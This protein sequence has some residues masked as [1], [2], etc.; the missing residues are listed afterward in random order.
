MNLPASN[1]S[2]IRGQVNPPVLLT[3]YPIIDQS[4]VLQANYETLRRQGQSHNMAEMLTF[5]QSPGAQTDR[6]F[7]MGHQRLA[8]QVGDDPMYMQQITSNYRAATGGL[9]PNINDQYMPSLANFPG[10]P[11]AFVSSAGD[12]KRLAEERNVSVSGFVT[13]KASEPIADPFGVGV[14]KGMKRQPIAN[15]LKMMIADQMV[16]QDPSKKGRVNTAALDEVH[17]NHVKVK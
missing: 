7:Q 5:R 1:N 16:K 13:H 11:R 15:D 2:R 10:D 3:G 8:D 14:P 6:E 9:S 4:P 17:G 12:V